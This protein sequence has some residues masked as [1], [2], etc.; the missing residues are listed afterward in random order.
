MIQKMITKVTQEFIH[1]P[2]VKSLAGLW[3]QKNSWFNEIIIQR[4]LT[5]NFPTSFLMIFQLLILI[6]A[7]NKGYLFAGIQFGGECW[8]GNSFGL[9]GDASSS[10]E[11]KF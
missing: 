3:D 5:E 1:Q 6:S 11:V 7:R 4:I 10:Y 9:H 2:V 8:C